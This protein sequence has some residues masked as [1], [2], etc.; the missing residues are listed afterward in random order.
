MTTFRKLTITAVV[1]GLF[2]TSAF[3]ATPE[4]QSLYKSKCASCHG[5]DGNASAIGKKLGARDFSMPEVM[6]QKD[7]EL[8]EITAKGKNKMPAFKEKLK[9]AEIKDLVAYLRE[10]GKK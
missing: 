10:M 3:A 9:E 6:K 8:I 1:F 7:A 4:T 2:A 5:A